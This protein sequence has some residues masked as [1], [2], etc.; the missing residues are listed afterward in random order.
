M[1]PELQTPVWITIFK[2]LVISVNTASNPVCFVIKDKAVANSYLQHF[3]TIWSQTSN[4][5]CGLCAHICSW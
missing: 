4:F 1:K 3:E 5:G 2:D